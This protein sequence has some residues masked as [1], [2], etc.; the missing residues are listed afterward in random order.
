MQRSDVKATANSRGVDQIILSLLLPALHDTR[1]GLMTIKHSFL[2]QS[3]L[4]GLTLG[5]VGGWVGRKRECT[6]R[7]KNNA[8]NPMR[9][10]KHSSEGGC[11]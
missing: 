6:C 11:P 3:H 5:W 10:Y 9:V 2:C 1:S 4:I 8:F 7:Y